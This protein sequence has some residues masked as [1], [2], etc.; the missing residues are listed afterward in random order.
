ML[1][2]Q[3]KLPHNFPMN[4]GRKALSALLSAPWGETTRTTRSF[5]SRQVNPQISFGGGKG[6]ESTYVFHH[7]AP[8]FPCLSFS[9]RLAITCPP[10]AHLILQHG[11]GERPYH[12]LGPMTANDTKLFKKLLI[13]V[14]LNK[15]TEAA[16]TLS[17]FVYL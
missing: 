14:L 2:P 1:S 3:T 15:Q 9:P 16:H 13:C 11:A 7:D 8:S 12:R 17:F 4:Y 6:T 5:N 10:I